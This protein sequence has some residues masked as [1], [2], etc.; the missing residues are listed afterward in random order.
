MTE[1]VGDSTTAGRRLTRGEKEAAI[2]DPAALLSKAQSQRVVE[3]Q[4]LYAESAVGLLGDLAESGFPVASVGELREWPIKYQAAVPVLVDWLPRVSYLP[5]VEDI[6]RTLSVPFAKKQALPTLLKFFRIPPSVE[7]P[8]RPASSEP[9]EEHLRWVVGNALGVFAAPAIADELIELALSREFGGARGQIVLSLPRVKDDRVPGVLV[10]LL[11][12]PTVA[13]SVIEA[14]GKMKFV[15]ARD[16]VR[17]LLDAPDK[18]VRD[19]AKKA[20]KRMTG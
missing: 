2:N 9:G 6:V 16:R 12:D 19:Q 17:D 10:S 5:L 15:D 11:D 3:R 20:L 7:D 4:R 8:M 1:E 13:P 18:N 14:L